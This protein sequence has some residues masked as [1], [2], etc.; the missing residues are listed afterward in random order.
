MFV[1]PIKLACWT[2]GIGCG[3]SHRNINGLELEKGSCVVRRYLIEGI[4]GEA[5]SCCEGRGRN[6]YDTARHLGRVNCFEERPGSKLVLVLGPSALN[7]S[8][9]FVGLNNNSFRSSN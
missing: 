8:T 7:H 9:L 1:I 5:D 4:C 2:R 6:D 3:L